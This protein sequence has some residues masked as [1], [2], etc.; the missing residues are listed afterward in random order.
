M[1]IFKRYG[2][3]AVL[4][5]ALKSG[6][7]M[8]ITKF[9][10]LVKQTVDDKECDQFKISCMLFKALE[11]YSKT[12]TMV[13]MWPWWVHAHNNPVQTHKV[14]AICRLLMAQH[15]LNSVV[16]H[17]NKASP[18][19]ALCDNYTVE[20]P[21]HLLFDCSYNTNRRAVLWTRFIDHVPN[22]LCQELHAMSSKEKTEFILSGFNC[23]FVP[24]WTHVYSAVLDYC[25]QLYQDRR[26]LSNVS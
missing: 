4:D 7:Y 10:A 23:N 14:R 12:T 8:S 5:A 1:C 18:L 19:C 24:E 25:Y 13:K 2:L 21:S 22:A 15:C 6:T 11:L 26:E 3:T 16:S 17:Y 9:K 20:T